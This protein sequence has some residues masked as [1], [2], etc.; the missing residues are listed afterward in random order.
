L[1][2]NE[3]STANDRAEGDRR[4]AEQTRR[5]DFWLIFA[6]GFSTCALIFAL[7]GWVLG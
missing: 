7:I 6:V 2:T 4:R 5:D 3:W 1:S